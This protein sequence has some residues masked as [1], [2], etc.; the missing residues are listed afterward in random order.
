MCYSS[1][2]F[3]LF[4]CFLPFITSRL[5]HRYASPEIRFNLMA[6]IRSRPEMYEEQLKEL[7]ARLIGNPNSEALNAERVT[8]ENRLTIEK[9]KF[10]RYKV[11]TRDLVA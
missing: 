9:E 7:D 5:A 4:V 6:L 2:I 8:L 11:C 1:L 10:R 3:V